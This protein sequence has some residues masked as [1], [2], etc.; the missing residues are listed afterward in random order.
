MTVIITGTRES[1][2]KRDFEFE[3]DVEEIDLTKTRIVDLKLDPLK[4][5]TRLK[6]IK[7]YFVK[8]QSFDLSGIGVCKSLREF[9]L[10]GN[11]LQ[12]IDLF[13]LRSCHNLEEIRLTTKSLKE[14]YLEGLEKCSQ[15][16]RFSLYSE[17]LGSV[18]L[19]PLST[20]YNLESF[21]IGLRSKSFINL[22]P[23]DFC[24]RLKQISIIGDTVIHIGDSHNIKSL[25][26]QM[27]K[28]R[29]D[30]LRSLKERGAI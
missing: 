21:A 22:T 12:S 14:V 20:C 8:T 1:G 6:I 11:Y 30:M 23:L 18:D 9:S 28:E 29:E 16:K 10:G 19:S 5:F 25:V 3:S 13:P 4:H 24:T 17:H 15:L 27:W 26:E 7:L 2:T